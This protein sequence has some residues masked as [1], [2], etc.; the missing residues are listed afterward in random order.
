VQSVEPVVSRHRFLGML[1]LQS[2]LSRVQRL[3]NMLVSKINNMK[4]KFSLISRPFDSK[5][6]S[7]LQIE[8][9]MIVELMSM[10]VWCQSDSQLLSVIVDSVDRQ[11][12][13][14]FAERHTLSFDR[15]QR[16][17]LNGVLSDNQFAESDSLQFNKLNGRR[18]DRQNANFPELSA[19]YLMSQQDVAVSVD[20]KF[21]EPQLF[22]KR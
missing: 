18:S 15:Q 16:D 21:V 6:L 11:R 2:N 22:V 7:L 10:I 20:R 19:G 9:M 14:Q 4:V 13:S 17:M 5:C 12:D 8:G 3:K 1:K